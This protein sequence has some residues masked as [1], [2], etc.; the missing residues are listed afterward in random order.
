MEFLDEQGVQ[1]CGHKAR[2]KGMIIKVFTSCQSYEIPTEY[3]Y[4]V[5]GVDNDKNTRQ[6]SFWHRKQLLTTQKTDSIDCSELRCSSKTI[7][8]PCTLQP[9]YTWKNVGEGKRLHL[10][11]GEDQGRPAWHYLLIEDVIDIQ[12]NFEAHF[13]EG[14]MYAGS[15]KLTNYGKILAS[16]F[17]ENPPNE[18]TDKINEEYL[19]RF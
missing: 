10:V 11:R 4:S 14:N 9:H 12:S 5:N 8:E 7:D 19:T 18:I 16:G 1:P 3:R 13:A 2:E 15:I 17:G 6:I